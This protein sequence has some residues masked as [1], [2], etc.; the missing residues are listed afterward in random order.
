QS[1]Q[2][3]TGAGFS[4]HAEETGEEQKIDPVFDIDRMGKGHL[5]GDAC[6]VIGKLEPPLNK[7]PVARP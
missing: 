7:T 2:V 1:C 6:I 3:G 5:H 4:I